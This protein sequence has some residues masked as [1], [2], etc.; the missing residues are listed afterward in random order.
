[1]ENAENRPMNVME[2]HLVFCL[3]PEL[4]SSHIHGLSKVYA[5]VCLS[6]IRQRPNS[7]GA[8]SGVAARELWTL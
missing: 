4:N 8:V 2:T 1:V 6:T 5:C 7:D 3:H